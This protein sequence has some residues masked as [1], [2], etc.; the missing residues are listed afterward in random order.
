MAHIAC[1]F[2]RDAKGN[3]DKMTMH[4]PQDAQGMRDLARRMIAAAETACRYTSGVS[5]EHKEGLEK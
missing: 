5:K 2:T 3:P 1:T 4:L